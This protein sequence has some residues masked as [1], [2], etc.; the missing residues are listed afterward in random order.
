MHSIGAS[1]SMHVALVNYELPLCF[2]FK[3]LSRLVMS[4]LYQSIYLLP[5]IVG[6]TAQN[7]SADWQTAQA[8]C[9]GNSTSAL[10]QTAI[11]N[12]ADSSPRNGKSAVPR[13]SLTIQVCQGGLTSMAVAPDGVS[14]ASTTKDG[15][16]YVHDLNTGALLR[17][18]KVSLNFEVLSLLCA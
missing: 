13:P 5:S 18:F 3:L 7:S 1:R 11:A 2:K 9:D 4:S 6:Q 17:G 16:L 10:Q 12:A 8:A 14:V 15:V